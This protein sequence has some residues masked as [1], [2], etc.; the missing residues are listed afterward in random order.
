MSFLV[1]SARK[2]GRFFSSPLAPPCKL[3]CCEDAC[4]L[5]CCEDDA[6]YNNSSPP[7]RQTLEQEIQGELEQQAREEQTAAKTVS[8]QRSAQSKS[9]QCSTQP[10]SQWSTQPNTRARQFLQDN[11]HQATALLKDVQELE[12]ACRDAEIRDRVWDL[13][14]QIEAFT[15]EHFSFQ[16]TDKTRLRAAFESMSKETVMIIG[17]VGPSGAREWEDVFTDTSKRQALVCAMIGNVLVEQVLQHMFFG[18]TAEQIEKVAAW[19][20]EHRNADG[21]STDRCRISTF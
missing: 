20:F 1:N 19:Q 14:D 12:Y 18:G 11:H 3:P 21:K 10:N 5:T 17:Y 8:W 13:M 2:L 4:K 9:R 6:G 7:Q 16:L 15:T